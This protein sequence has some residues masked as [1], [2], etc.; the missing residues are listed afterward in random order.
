MK[1]VPPEKGVRSILTWGVH[2]Q[3]SFL[4]SRES[5][6]RRIGKMYCKKKRRGKYKIMAIASEGAKTTLL[7]S[8]GVCIL[9]LGGQSHNGVSRLGQTLQA[10]NY[11]PIR[12]Q[13]MGYVP[14]HAT[15]P[16]AITDFSVQLLV[17]YGQTERHSHCIRFD[18]D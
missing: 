12:K 17:H 8:Q 11:K 3:R 7:V 2:P 16:T 10:P 9:R 5:G 1:G 4:R 13:V 15:L 6:I 14:G 18:L